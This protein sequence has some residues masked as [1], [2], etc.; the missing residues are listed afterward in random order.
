MKKIFSLLLVSIVLFVSTIIAYA[1]APSYE[2]ITVPEMVAYLEDNGIPSDFLENRTDSYIIMLYNKLSCIDFIYNGS[3]TGTLTETNGLG[4]EPMGNIPDNELTFTITKI[5]NVSYD[6]T[7]GMDRVNEVYL[8]IDYEWATGHPNM[9][10]K[11]A[12]TINWDAGIFT[13]KNNS[14]SA[15]D[16]KYSILKGDWITSD[17]LTRP[18][19]AQQGGI[20]YYANLTYTENIMGQTVN[21]AQCKGEASLTL[22]RPSYVFDCRSINYVN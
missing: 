16:Y 4:I 11:D 7:A 10:K 17:T 2:S 13:Y 5:S 21:A 19:M 20:G 6:A 12:I 22:A 15:T 3:T 18:A 14:F 9:R 8:Y 1:G